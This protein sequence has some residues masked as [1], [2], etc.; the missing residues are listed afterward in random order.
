M[1]YYHCTLL[2]FFLLLLV[3]LPMNGNMNDWVNL[4]KENRSS[5]IS[6]QPLSIIF[7]FT[8][9]NSIQKFSNLTKKIEE[10]T[11]TLPSTIPIGLLFSPNSTEE[12]SIHIYYEDINKSILHKHLKENSTELIISEIIDIYHTVNIHYIIPEEIH[13]FS[14]SSFNQN[15]YGLIIFSDNLKENHILFHQNISYQIKEVFDVYA[16]SIDNY[17]K[18]IPLFNVS[19]SISFESTNEDSSEYIA[20]SYNPSTQDSIVIH[21]NGNY[22]NLFDVI[23]L[24]SFPNT[25][26]FNNPKQSNVINALKQSS[27]GENF[28]LIYSKEKD[29]E[30]VLAQF[31]EIAEIFHMKHSIPVW[32]GYLN[33]DVFPDE[34]DNQDL[35]TPICFLYETFLDNDI[36]SQYTHNITFEELYYALYLHNKNDVEEENEN[37]TSENPTEEEVEEEGSRLKSLYEVNDEKDLYQY[38]HFILFIY[39]E[40]KESSFKYHKFIFMLER[41]HYLLNEEDYP[42]FSITKQQTKGKDLIHISGIKDMKI[43]LF[44]KDKKEDAFSYSLY[45]K[46]PS[47]S[48]FCDFFNTVYETEFSVSEKEVLRYYDEMVKN[49]EHYEKVMEESSKKIDYLKRDYEDDDEVLIDEGDD[50]EDVNYAD[51]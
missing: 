9:N 23:M 26:N 45:E 47:I 38:D 14:P 31:D 43:V 39:D 17:N 4:S 34:K 32:F 10:Q 42:I 8:N 40:N 27:W 3:I 19:S 30:E 48:L 1:I 13:L 36:E 5:F 50:E 29:G 11:N 2:Y 18:L 28:I 22:I 49:D 37:N 35:T 12:F 33:I 46:G 20:L 16:S 15:K 25:I 41:F 24:Y 7:K 6:E 51:L 21:F 44:S